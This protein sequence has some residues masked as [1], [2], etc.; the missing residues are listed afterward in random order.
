MLFKGLPNTTDF[1]ILQNG[2]IR[3][4]ADYKQVETNSTELKDLGY[5]VINIEASSCDDLFKELNIKLFEYENFTRSW[6]TLNDR[7]IELYD[8]KKDK[9]K[10]V[11]IYFSNFDYMLDSDKK[12][13]L[14]VFLDNVIYNLIF[15]FPLLVLLMSD[16]KVI[17]VEKRV[18]KEFNIGG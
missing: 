4:C 13:L 18:N 3:N 10:G 5:L 14:S 12:M 7:L 8:L 2:G 11:A 6:D 16:S 17:T 15:E 9:Y 1:M